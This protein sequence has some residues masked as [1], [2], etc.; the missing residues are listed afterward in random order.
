MIDVMW[1]WQRCQHNV[2]R[3][4]TIYTNQGAQHAW[5]NMVH[6]LGFRTEPSPYDPNHVPAGVLE[7]LDAQC[8]PASTG[9]EW[10]LVR[11]AVLLSLPTGRLP[12]TTQTCKGQKVS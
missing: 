5:D 8:G 12:A 11:G 7:V 6:E 4:C 3:L 2:D 10:A 1:Y 9:T